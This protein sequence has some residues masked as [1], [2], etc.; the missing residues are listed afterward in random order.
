MTQTLHGKPKPANPKKLYGDKKPP[1]HFI[2]PIAELHESAAL[3][4]GALKYGENNYLETPVE[5]MT[6]VGAIK[7]HLSQWLSGERVDAKELVHH[8]GAIKACCTILMTTEAVGTLIDNRPGAGIQPYPAPYD[9]ARYAAATAATFAEVEGIIE[10][11][12][13]LYPPVN[14]Q[15]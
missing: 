4:S 5:A 10:H 1:V 11:L 2:H 3:K 6:Y 8:L 7:R 9:Q 15:L 14:P 13:A 12:N